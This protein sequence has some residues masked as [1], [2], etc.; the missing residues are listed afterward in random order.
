MLKNIFITF[1]ML[2]VFLTEYLEESNHQ[3]KYEI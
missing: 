1:F 3:Y 2:L